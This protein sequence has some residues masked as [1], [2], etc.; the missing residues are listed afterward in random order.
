[1]NNSIGLATNFHGE[2]GPG[3]VRTFGLSSYEVASDSRSLSVGILAEEGDSNITVTSGHSVTT[4]LK[5]SI[6]FESSTGTIEALYGTETKTASGTDPSARLDLGLNFYNVTSKLQAV[7]GKSDTSGKFVP[8]IG[9]SIQY[10]VNP[11]SGPEQP[12]PALT[13]PLIANMGTSGY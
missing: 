2:W 3:P 10:A 1:M 11:Q 4:G 9:S 8:P 6:I 5:I 12:T 7:L 13:I